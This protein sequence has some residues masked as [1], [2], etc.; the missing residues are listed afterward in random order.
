MVEVYGILSF[1]H[2]LSLAPIDPVIVCAILSMI[3]Q[4]AVNNG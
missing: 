4:H 2:G 3:K 1:S